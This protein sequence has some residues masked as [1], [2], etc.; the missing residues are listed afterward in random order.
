MGN[1]I[2]ILSIDGGNGL[3]AAQ[4]L[5]QLESV[6]YSRFLDSTDIFTG[7]SAGGINALFFASSER[8][9]KLQS[10]SSDSY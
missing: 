8:A 1:A 4:L 7:T 9:M 10:V 6:K 2:N 5:T 3:N